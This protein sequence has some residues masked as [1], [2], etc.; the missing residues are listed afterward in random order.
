MGVNGSTVGE[1]RGVDGW[2]GRKGFA[3]F[4]VFWFE[5]CLIF[6]GSSLAGLIGGRKNHSGCPAGA[7]ELG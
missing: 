1:E 5:K 3:L 4:R 7:A 2:T 6:L